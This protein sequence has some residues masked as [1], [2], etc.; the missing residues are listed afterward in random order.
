MHK[1]LNDK[2]FREKLA[3]KAE[4][5]VT[6]FCH[7]YGEES[8]RFTADFVRKTVKYSQPVGFYFGNNHTVKS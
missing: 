8:A 7:V 6:K 1:I 5:Y 3:L 2:L 4:E